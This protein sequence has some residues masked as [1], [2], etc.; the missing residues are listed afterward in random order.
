MGLKNSFPGQSGTHERQGGGNTP[1]S[2]EKHDQKK[3]QYVRAEQRA[4]LIDNPGLENSPGRAS[5]D[6]S[7]GK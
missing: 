4:G 6:V 5:A 1:V 7:K 2:G 3:A